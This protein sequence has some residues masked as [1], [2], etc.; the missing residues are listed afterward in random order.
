MPIK[1]S[2]KLHLLLAL[3]VPV[4]LGG[5]AGDNTVSYAQDIQ[6]ILEKHCFQCHTQGGEGLKASGLDMSSHASLM[7]GTRFGPIIKPGDSLSSTMIILVEG[8][9]PS[10]KMPHNEGAFLSNDE[11]NTL[12]NWIDQ[13]AK[14]N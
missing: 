5:C 12:R 14:N 6:P 10:L 4:I 3:I 2:T 8:R 7:K 9:A 1:S 11:T 13:G